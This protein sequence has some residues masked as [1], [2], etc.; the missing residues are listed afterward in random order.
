MSGEHLLTFIIVAA[1]VTWICY[2]AM[3]GPDRE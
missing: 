2:V 3:G 1:A